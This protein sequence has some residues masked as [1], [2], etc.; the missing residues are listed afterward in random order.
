MTAD[1]KEFSYSYLPNA[2]HLISQVTAPLHTVTHTYEANRDMLTSK[3]NRWENK[4]DYPIISAY[5]YI[6]N[7]FG[8]RTS[9]STEGEAFGSA[10]ANWAWGYDVL[11]QINS[12]NGDSYAYDQIGNRKTS[13]KGDSADTVYTANALNQYSRIGTTVPAYDADGNQLT[14]LTP[15]T[16]VPDRN[17]LSF[18]YNAE[19]RPVNVAQ[20]GEVRESYSYDHMG[21]RIRKGDTVT[22]YDGYNAIAEYKSNTRTLKTTYAWGHD[23]SGTAQDAGGVGGLLSVTEHDRQLPLTSYPCY[24]D[25]GNITEYLTEEGAGTIAAHYE[26]DAF[27]HV[28]RKT[29]TRDYGYQFSTKPS[30]SLTGLLYYNYRYYDPSSGR[31]MGRD[32]MEEDGGDN[33][34][35]FVS[36]RPDRQI[37]LLGL[38]GVEIKFEEVKP[39]DIT[40]E[41]ITTK[42]GLGSKSSFELKIECECECKGEGKQQEIKMVC[43]IEYTPKIILDKAQAKPKR[44]VYGRPVTLT[45][46]YGHEQ[47]HIQFRNR[48]MKEYVKEL[49]K[50]LKNQSFPNL[51][52]CKGRTKYT[53]SDISK[54]LA[55]KRRREDQHSAPGK[56][57]N[58]DSSRQPELAVPYN[59]VSGSLPVE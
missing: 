53:K 13:R 37:D 42:N 17:T 12:A 27:G 58:G 50:D 33:L 46:I 23:L 59:P 14:G 16:T 28:S 45:G 35:A 54:K 11:G 15:T 36:N 6:V 29:G 7:S 47:L 8:Q 31:W 10:P 19:N 56:N 32:S 3:T 40:P 55:K 25:N 44:I 26:Y 4:V 20:N 43:S 49:E 22:L 51:N 38:K 1:G 30:D 48:K 52:N 24:D 21:R 39:E 2:P 34:Y 18:T 57:P 5:T 41:I 9:V